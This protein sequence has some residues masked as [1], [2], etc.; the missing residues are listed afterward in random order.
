MSRS[1]VAQLKQKYIRD[2]EKRLQHSLTIAEKRLFDAIF[3]KLISE[4]KKSEG[5]IVSDGENIKLSTA[6]DEIFKEFEKNQ[7]LKIV[8]AFAIDLE[9]VGKLNERYYEIVSEDQK[10]FEKINKEVKSIMRQRI[11]I[12]DKGNI[13][14]DGYL[15]R[16]IK[17][18]TLKQKIKETTLK[19]V[20]SGQSFDKYVSSIEKII[21]GNKNVNGGLQKH[22]QQ[23]AYDTFA[24][25]NRTSSKL[26]A[27]KLDL[28]AFIYQGGE[29]QTSRCFCIENDGK[30]F[31]VEE[32]EKWKSKV[33][34]ECGP[35]MEK[36]A[37]Y[38]PL[39]DMGGINCRHSVDFISQSM[40]LRLRPDLKGKI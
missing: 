18:N 25:Y 30:V 31:T 15:D 17:D 6:L 12:N 13:S 37:I 36:D 5:K 19:A 7:Y 16:L 28:K 1:E 33:N 34:K 20:T 32:A 22:F 11:G 27:E 8:N 3:N 35:V 39:I 38:N 10:K 9:H 21:V 40:A 26:Y 23:F 4:L 29:I 2:A 14:K 24:Q